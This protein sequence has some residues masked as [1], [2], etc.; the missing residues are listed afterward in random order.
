[1]ETT[2]Q[3][4]VAFMIGVLLMAGAIITGWLAVGGA[5]NMYQEPQPKPPATTEYI[6]A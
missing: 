1:M 5:E 3:Q 4:L 6:D 2:G